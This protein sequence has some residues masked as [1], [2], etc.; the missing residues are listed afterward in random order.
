MSYR[1]QLFVALAFGAAGIISLP[2]AALSPAATGDANVAALLAGRANHALASAGGVAFSSTDLGPDYAAPRV[3]DG[4]IDHTGNSWIPS[5]TAPTD[6]VAVRFGAAQ[7]VSALVFHGQT[8]YNGRSAGTWSLQYTTDASPAA[9]S[10]WNEIGT[11]TYAEAGCAQPMPRSYFSFTP[12]A[13]VT[14]VRL[15]LLNSACSIQLA[16]QELEAFSPVAVTPSVTGDAPVAAAISGRPN[17]AA[18][19]GGATA[20]SSS[21]LNPDY[22]ASRVND[23]VINHTGNSWIPLTT[24]STESVAVRLATPADIDSIVFH[25]QTGYNGRSAGTWSIEYTRDAAPSASSS[26]AHLGNYVYAEAGCATPMPRSFFSFNVLSNV[27]GVRLV[28]QNPA[29][30]IQLA[31]QE[32]E[33]YGPLVSPPTIEGQPSGGTVVAGNDFTFTVSA[34]GA[35]VFQWRKDGTA[36][37]G[38]TA[39]SLVLSDVKLSD[40][41]T[42]SVR[43]ANSAGAVTSDDATLTVTPA[44][45]FA[46][47]T[48]AVLADNPIHYY[49]LDETSGTTAADL[50]SLALAG[51]TYTGGFTLGQAAATTGLGRCVRLDGAPGTLIDLGLFHAG[52][53]ITVEAWA[54][55]DPTAN[56]N[57]SYHAIVARWDGSYELDFA[58]GDIGNMV[59]KRDGNGFGLAAAST[60]SA[61]G[62]W[63]HLVGVFSGGTVTIYVDGVKGSEQTIGGVL[64]DAGPS[65]DRV[66][67][68]ATR[69]G[70]AGSFNFKGLIDEVAIY[71]T[72]LTPAQIR[73]HFRASQPAPPS[74]TIQNAVI[75]SWPSFP[76]GYV[77]QASGQVQGPYTNYTGSVFTEGGNFIAPVPIGPAQKFFQLFKP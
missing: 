64:Q 22:A 48:E 8:G 70:S 68:G 42:Y 3:N 34:S 12:I 71:D 47:Y 31:V 27:T 61:R 25:G 49:P 6:F 11:Y 10:A 76:G 5:T 45:T 20:F 60:P 21:D 30:A 24:A 35:S 66:M 41:G 46:T 59:V 15:L 16:V 26:W 9:G 74:L 67:I 57:P 58:P 33:A 43:V 53:S 4:V 77:L 62:Q 50:G 38:A 73:A 7:T 69:T 23:G 56:N 29:C 65:P 44:P 37:P 1:T 51:G 39:S 72:A 36:I 17:L 63:H 2:A 18:A 54:N 19:S 28:L 13:N 40:A 32:L 14:A 55:L 52:D 75:V